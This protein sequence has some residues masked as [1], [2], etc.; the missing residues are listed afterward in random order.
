[1]ALSLWLWFATQTAVNSNLRRLLSGGTRV[2]AGLLASDI[3]SLEASLSRMSRRWLVLKGTPPEIWSD[4]AQA[5]TEIYPAIAA[6]ERLDANLRVR[7]QVSGTNEDFTV[8]AAADLS[9][10]EREKILATRNDATVIV[11][12]IKTDAGGV[13]FVTLYSPLRL[14]D[15]QDGF[16][17]AR[18]NILRLFETILKRTTSSNRLDIYRDGNL[19]F[20]LGGEPAKVP[21]DLAGTAIAGIN[22]LLFELKMRPTE[23]YLRANDAGFPDFLLGVALTITILA[24]VLAY[25]GAQA[26]LRSRDLRD[27]LALITDQERRYR[28]MLRR[29]NMGVAVTDSDGRVLEANEPYLRILGCTEP[30]QI[31]G[32]SIAEFL[33]EG[34]MEKRTA[35]I[36]EALRASGA[37]Q[38]NIALRQRGGKHVLIS[39]NTILDRT[40][41]GETRLVTLAEDIT[42]NNRIQNEII[43]SKRIYEEVFES[44]DIAIT[45]IDMSALFAHLQDLRGHGV[46]DLR[47]YIDG[48]PKRLEDIC[49]LVKLNN[50]NQAGLRLFGGQSVRQLREMDYFMEGGRP[51]QMREMALAMWEGI[52]SIRKEVNYTSFTGK[53]IAI[54]YSLRLPTGIEEARRVP[55][56]TMDVTDIRSAESARQANV[57]KTQFLASMSHEIRTPLN[58][59]I[60]NLEL[61]A[62]TELEE[63]QESLLFDAEKAA[64]SLL[65][66]I[67]NILDFSKIEAGKLTVERV[68][69]APS[70]IVQEAVDI[71]Q[72]RARQ[73]GIFVTG[74]MGQDL[75]Q[76]VKGDP[77]RIRQ[78]LL[79]LL[80]NAVKFTAQ[81]GVHVNL[82]AQPVDER[83]CKLM[84]YVHDSGRGFS[85]EIAG[86]LFL[87]FMQDHKQS[88]EDYGGT[89]LGLSI[90]KSLVETFGGEIG[91]E[92]VPEQGASF[93][94]SVPVEIVKP[95]ASAPQVPDL[96][97]RKIMFVMPGGAE[98]PRELLDYLKIRNGALTIARNDSEALTLSRQSASNGKNIDIAVYVSA[99]EQWPDLGF[100]SALRDNK[101]VPM[102]YASDAAPQT[103]R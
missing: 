47:Q 102:V 29:A 62:Q 82:T 33:P 46:R 60:G 6:V 58:G 94:F 95:P 84:F 39:A 35:H 79:N 22:E 5:L 97:L 7:W 20:S 24:A 48:G 103:W 92:S 15:R 83:T 53:H 9:D 72:S 12:D 25:F 50:I 21:D 13:R 68:D 64:K 65:A 45:D 80:G 54:I 26:A 28:E 43:E 31:I 10:Q 89:G 27:A 63:D 8:D 74:F 59:V 101:T 32:H 55:V 57:A 51:A 49:R 100:T 87:P 88:F 66:L 30:E 93:W 73:K 78:I 56:I 77:T 99:P 41:S 18:I 71:V 44:S 17:A 23:R 38:R 19:M 75:P 85:Q 61:L 4:E 42:E 11:G 2:H 14:P 3:E 16:V 70:L 69:L 86:D 52:P 36:T 90:C 76:V 98:P 34:G 96:T 91:C 1:M 40:P 37:V 67:G 81:G